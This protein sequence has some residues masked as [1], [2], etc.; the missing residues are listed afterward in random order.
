[1]GIVVDASITVS[2]CFPDEQTPL[3]LKVL[4]RLNTGEEAVVPSFWAVEI[5]NSLLVGEKRGR[6]SPEQTRAFLGDLAA[7]KPTINHASYDQVFGMVHVLSRDHEL[8]PYRR[9]RVGTSALKWP[10]SWLATPPAKRLLDS[11]HRCR[12]R[13]PEDGRLPR[14]RTA[15][16]ST[17]CLRNC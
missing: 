3:S 4:D 5:L 7:L 10:Q 15:R 12:A 13:S 6:I 11:C 16:A 9:S 17:G 8:P 14:S 2:W 1:M